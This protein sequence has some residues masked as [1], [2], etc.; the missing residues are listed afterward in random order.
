M[1]EKVGYLETKIDGQV[2]KS[3]KRLAAMMVLIPTLIV[4]IAVMI[5]SIFHKMADSETITKC[6]EILIGFVVI[7]LVGGTA[8]EGMSGFI[9]NKFGNHK[10]E[11]E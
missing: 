10:Q 1:V 5:I 2:E 11:Q 3:S 4:L 7:I 8:A 9:S 6:G